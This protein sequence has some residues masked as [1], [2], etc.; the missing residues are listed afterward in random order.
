MP[1]GLIIMEDA[2]AGTTDGD[3]PLQLATAMPMGMAMEGIQT[4]LKRYRHPSEESDEVAS[5]E[6]GD[7]ASNIPHKRKQTSV[8]GPGHSD[9]GDMYK[10]LKEIGLRLGAIESSTRKMEDQLNQAFIVMRADVE[11][12]KK[13]SNNNT[14]EIN[15]IKK[16]MHAT[17]TRTQ[18]IPDRQLRN[19]ILRQESY[20][21]KINLIIEGVE[22][23]RQPE[24]GTLLKQKVHQ[25]IRGRMGVS[26]VELDVVHRIG[27]ALPAR[28]RPVLVRFAKLSDQNKVWFARMRLKASEGS[29]QPKYWIKEDIP[30]EV[31]QLNDLLYKSCDAAKKSGKY[32]AV[33][34]RNYKL[35]LDGLAYT[36]DDL[37]QLPVELRPS[38]LA[39]PRS[40]TTLAFFSKRTPLSNHYKCSFKVEGVQYSSVEQFMARERA[41]FS[42][43]QPQVVTKIMKE[44]DPIQLKSIMFHLRRDRRQKD[45]ED[46]AAEKIKP[47]LIAKF[48][49]NDDLRR[50]LLETE[51]RILGEAAQRDLFWGIGL[52]LRAKEVLDRSKWKGKNTLG[53]LLMEVR[54]S[55]R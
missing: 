45:W 50:V 6:R 25:I 39:A 27:T 34:V 18:S 14:K 54:D 44:H 4:T 15:E 21:R 49:Q 16:S 37:E 2:L 9:S 33:S 29:N 22:E 12:V 31:R 42:G 36:E 5:C 30:T 8:Q 1:L 40:D 23:G 51:N 46:V 7:N 28:P 10:I 24:D 35:Y 53:T 43:A 13:A 41:V 38:T 32:A 52:S 11:E 48:A 20:S 17:L 3:Q 55:Y 19:D 47:G 26:D